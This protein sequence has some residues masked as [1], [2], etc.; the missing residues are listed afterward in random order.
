VNARYSRERAAFQ[1][2]PRV[3]TMP[4]LS[5]LSIEY[6][7]AVALWIQILGIALFGLIA[8][9]RQWRRTHPGRVRLVK[10]GLSIWF[11]AVLLTGVELYF[12]LIHD[13]S[14][15]FNV[16]NVS[17]RWYA[18]HATPDERSLTCSGGL[19]VRY[20]DDRDF[21][22]R[23][24]D[25]T[26]H[27]CFVG[28][29]FTYGHGIVDMQS[30]FSNRVRIAY[31][32]QS[33]G[34]FAFSNL[35]EPGRDVTWVVSLA[36]ALTEDAMR[37]D[38]LVYVLCLNDIEKCDDRTEALLQEMG[39][40]APDTFLF[41]DTYFFNL[42]Y[43]RIRLQTLPGVQDYFAFLTESYRSDAWRKMQT[44]L[45]ELRRICADGGIQ[46]RIVLFPFLHNLGQGYPFDDAHA[47]IAAFC[48]EQEIPLLDLKP[49]LA[50][51]S[52]EGLIVNRFDAH[53][54]ERAHALAAEAIANDLSADLTR[55]LHTS[56]PRRDH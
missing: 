13:H 34:R 4:S 33:P 15:S 38:L 23:L 31:D 55:A 53:P 48:A 39:R 24:P 9:P 8:I 41:R 17:K 43:C 40:R 28:D 42:L 16:T 46:L 1:L 45:L 26:R 27:V 7:A 49:M 6:L 36:S 20:R 14:D 32:R 52:G 35:A 29:S 12:A 5:Y 44:Q 50:S 30:R 51:H 11:F 54:N 2:S 19:T 21:P 18:R 37:V 56:A 10:C 3:K 22:R 25:E 47:A